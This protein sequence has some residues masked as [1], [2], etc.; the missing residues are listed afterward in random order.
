M[1]TINVLFS[2][3][4]G[5]GMIGILNHLKK[6]KRKINIHVSDIILKEEIK[7]FCDSY[8]IV[9]KISSPGYKENIINLCRKK[10][11]DVIIPC[12]GDDVLFYASNIDV[13]KRMGMV[14]TV[15]SVES[16]RKT[17]DKKLCFE[18][19]QENG[20]QVPEFYEVNTKLEFESAAINLDYPNNP[21]CFKPAR[22][23]NGSGKGFRIIDPRKDISRRLFYELTSELYVVDYDFVI[24]SFGKV[25][26]IPSLLVMEYLPG[27]EY[28]V[29]CF[30]DKGEAKYIVPNL[31]ITTQQMTTTSAVV[32]Y[33]KQII[34][35][36]ERICKL[37]GF[38]YNV[39]IQLKVGIDGVPKLVEINPRLAGTILLPVFA[40]PD[41][42]YY[43]I[44]KAVGE[45]YSVNKPINYGS[46]IIRYH[47]ELFLDKDI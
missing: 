9:P 46:K 19:A 2:S 43:S 37:F 41:I 47:K 28:S 4:G 24:N 33:D 8:T 45:Q 22:Y 1:K 3:G 40:G 25:N 44:L 14:P 38:D 5:S 35:I 31:R 39:N 34:D 20:I 36:S 21:I 32:V 7:F 16:S 17:L 26:D 30:C 18:I 13:F 27:N 42:I 11:I 29:Y 23:P 10:D 12:I 6:L 15:S